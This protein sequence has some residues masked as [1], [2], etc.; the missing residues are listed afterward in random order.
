MLSVQDDVDFRPEPERFRPVFDPAPEAYLRVL[1]NPFLAAWAFLTWLFA[2]RNYRT[3]IDA[4]AALGPIGP[5]L[6]RVA[7]GLGAL[8]A[9]LLLQYHC[10]D[11]GATGRI[12]GWRRHACG[13]VV[14]RRR[15]GRPLRL[16]LPSPGVQMIFWVAAVAGVVFL[17]GRL[18]PA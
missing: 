8:A 7:L 3:I 9:P 12:G 4:A 18:I 13:A 17:L 14:E 16:V 2:A 1:A 5:D 6:A 15:I 10:L 11:C